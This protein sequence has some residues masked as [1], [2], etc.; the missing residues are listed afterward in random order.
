[1]FF[2]SKLYSDRVHARYELTDEVV[3]KNGFQVIVY[4]PRSEKRIDQVFE[5]LTFGSL[6]V[7]YLSKSYRIDPNKIPWVD[8]FKNKLSKADS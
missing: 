6:M 4:T 1:M 7:Y 3:S 5:V 8:Y 2:D